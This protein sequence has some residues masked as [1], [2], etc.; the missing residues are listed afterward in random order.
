MACEFSDPKII[1]KITVASIQT[2]NFID[3]HVSQT[4]FWW[5]KLS[6]VVREL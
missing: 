2:I 5:H 1:V 4:S 6:A 3:E